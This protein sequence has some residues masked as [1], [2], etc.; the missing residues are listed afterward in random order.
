MILH[1]VKHLASVSDFAEG[2]ACLCQTYIDQY[3]DACPAAVQVLAS[4]VFGLRFKLHL[5]EAWWLIRQNLPLIS[6]VAR[7]PADCCRTEHK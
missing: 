7:E 1:E 6:D 4:C 3:H 5:P 2:N